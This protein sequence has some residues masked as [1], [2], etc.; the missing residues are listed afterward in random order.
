MAAGEDAH[1]AADAAARLQAWFQAE[2]PLVMDEADFDDVQTV[3]ADNK[4]LRQQLAEAT[5]LIGRFVDHEDQPC[6]FDHHGAYQEHGG[7]S[8]RP[9][10]VAV[11]REWLARVRGVGGELGCLCPHT[12]QPDGRLVRDGVL[13]A[14]CPVHDPDEEPTCGG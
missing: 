7:S 9:C 2:G 14:G 12:Y 10:D 5:A 11:G 3:L 1:E 8:L 13:A 4:R 6:R